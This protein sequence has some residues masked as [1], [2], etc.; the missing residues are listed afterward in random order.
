MIRK[1]VDFALNNRSSFWRSLFCCSLGEL[2]PSTIFRWKPYPDVA[3]N[4]VE[5]ITQ[6]PGISAEANRAAGNHSARNSHERDS[7][8][9]ESALVFPVRAFRSE[10]G[11]LK[12]DPR[13][14]G[15]ASAYWSGWRKSLCRPGSVRRWGPTG[16]RG[17]DLFLHPAQH[18]SKI[19]RHGVEV[20]RGLGDRKEF[21]NQCQ[22]GGCR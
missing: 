21:L 4:Y 9:R 12:T 20:D 5:I 22:R 15:T 16:A 18:Q 17:A 7:R 3:N 6:W 13:T 2:S 11:V 19:R 1:A 10:A 14:P 8:C